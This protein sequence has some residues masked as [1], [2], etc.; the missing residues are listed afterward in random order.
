[1][2][3][4][5]L[6]VL[7][8]LAAPAA[9]QVVNAPV[10]P[11]TIY[12][13]RRGPAGGL[14]VIDL[15]GFGAS[16]GDPTYDPAGL[17]FQ[18]GW[19]LYPYNPNVRLQGAL[20]RPPL[21]PG[22]STINGGSAGVFTLTRNSN[23]ENLLLRSPAVQSISDM[24]LGA[25]LDLVWSEAPAP[26]GCQA[27]GGNLC[28][29][30]GLQVASVALGLG[31][32][33]LVPSALGAPQTLY[34]VQQ[35]G[36]PISWAPHPNPPPLID[37]P[38]CIAPRIAGQEPTSVETS[39]ANLLL[40]G[41][42]MGNPGAG[43]PPTGL[44]ASEPNTHFA[45]PSLPA[46]T[47]GACQPYALRQQIGH[48]LYLADRVAGEIVVANSNTLRVLARIPVADATELAMSPDL[49]RLAVTQPALDRVSFLDID[50]LSAGF[51]TL[52]GSTQVEDQP[53]GIAWTPDNEDILVCNQGSNSVSI[54]SAFNLQ[55]RRTVRRGLDQPFAIA[56]TPRET[57][58]G[59]SRNVYLAWILD[60]SGHVSLFESG[61]NGVNGWGFDDIIWRTPWVFPRAK[62]IQP[63]PLRLAP[64]VWIAH[65]VKLDA[66]GN[67]TTQLGGAVSN[68]IVDSALP[69]PL[70]LQFGD[71]PNLRQRTLRIERSIGDDQLS[72]VPTDLAFDDQRNLGILPVVPGAFGVGGVVSING[73]HS[74]RQ[75]NGQAHNTN[76]ATYLFLPVRGSV[77]GQERVDVIRISNGQRVDTNPH[78]PGLQSIP[79][80]GAAG[81][82]SYFR[83]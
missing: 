73:K 61:P 74:V 52:T 67:P 66:N 62:A 18:E 30:A 58:F 37:P 55:V 72:G 44:L 46:G 45:G 15:N 63:D 39:V 38:L 10:A 7:F 80:P 79:A 81:V 57:N 53:M 77:P 26:Q 11:D 24:M 22:T 71:V 28:A 14:S 68:L 51:H 78:Q 3:H 47:I 29:I 75:V 69:G 60:R 82:A 35:G 70:P 49:K 1:M 34:S 23:L 48:F 76:E 9:A 21:L 20:L 6:P 17:V 31:A 25:P 19:S 12:L 41:D 54:L 56:I 8:L 32:N 27:G 33:V 16:T 13:A 59:F 40:P 43:V 5:T 50:P 2:I 42:P 4:R 36:N 83:Q 65:E 64:S